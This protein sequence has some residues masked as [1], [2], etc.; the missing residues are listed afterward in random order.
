MFKTIIGYDALCFQFSECIRNKQVPASFLISGMPYS[1]RLRIAL[2]FA[3]LLQCEEQGTDDCN[4]SSCHAS[5]SFQHS[6][7]K[8]LGGQSDLLEIDSLMNLAVS[9]KK[10]KT[11]TALL[12]AFQLLLARADLVIWENTEA[13]NSGLKKHSQLLAEQLFEYAEDESGWYSETQLK[14]LRTGAAQLVQSFPENNYAVRLIRNVSVWARIQAHSKVKVVIFEKADAM[15]PNVENMLLKILEEGPINTV[16]F[17]IADNPNAL[18]QTTRSRLF[19][20]QLPLRSPMHEKQVIESVYGL[21]EA[22]FSA[23]QF[24][25][26]TVHSFIQYFSLISKKELHA[27]ITAFFKGVQEH[28]RFSGDFLGFLSKNQK[29]ASLTFLENLRSE[30]RSAL[31]KQ[32]GS[33]QALFLMWKTL[34][35]TRHRIAT[36][37]LSPRYALESMYYTLVRQHERFFAK[38]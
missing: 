4:C 33:A 9:A 21:T 34:E 24:S 11:R 38:N 35:E 18:L 13:W 31:L 36:Y 14:R 25:P 26:N 23:K 6:D 22:D 30:I 10:E 7:V 17:L 1:G 8:I 29:K 37:N 12:H 16:F 2:E 15:S 3:R 20:I 32:K 28:K 19:H 27:D 5:R